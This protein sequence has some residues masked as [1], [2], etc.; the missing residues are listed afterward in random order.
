VN[1]EARLKGRLPPRLEQCWGCGYH[2]MPGTKTCPHCG[3]DVA[4][5]RKKHQAAM[6]KA[7]AA[8][9]KLDAI[10]ARLQKKA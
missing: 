9:A 10:L 1:G 4:K 7:T 5:L 6:K 2:V 8:K 3:S